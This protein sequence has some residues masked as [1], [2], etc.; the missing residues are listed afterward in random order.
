MALTLPTLDDRTFADLVAEARSL[1][2]V[3]DPGWTNHNP[4]DPGITL[5]EL[6]AW[7]VEALIYQLDQITD[8]HK[9]VFLKLLNGPGWKPK[10]ALDLEVR[11][12]L[13]VLR[14]RNRAVTTEDY[15]FLA[16]RASASVQRAKCLARRNLEARTEALRQTDA[17]GQI[18]VIVLPSAANCDTGAV[19]QAVR[20]DLEPRRS[21]TTRLHV[22]G[23][24]FVPI[25]SGVV[26][27]RRSD[28]AK[29]ILATRVRDRVVAWLEPILGGAGSGWPFGRAVMVSELVRV[30]EDVDGVDYIGG[31]DLTCPVAAG[32]PAA[33]RAEAQWHDSG[34]L[35]GLLLAPHHLPWADQESVAVTVL[36]AMIPLGMSVTVTAKAGATAAAVRR[37][38]KASLKT[39]LRTLQ[40]Q[41]AAAGKG[42]LVESAK[43]GTYLRE[44]PAVAEM[45][46]DVT[47][48]VLTAASERSEVT[49]D[50]VT[51]VVYFQPGEAVLAGTEITVTESAS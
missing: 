8:Q 4:S 3:H 25:T 41:A 48:I 16:M 51:T 13:R 46:T 17:P 32:D 5:I 27:V 37:T 18:S 21:L 26:V 15:E 34:D 45:I 47:A 1:I 42:Y 44:D 22:V 11:D 19:C 50:D 7:L 6:F 31:V 2:P 30:V 49:P 39:G 14:E 38:V 9:I 43:V 35:I 28:V 29:D 20:D 23:P 33:A 12:S 24:S 10:Q 40:A 36:D